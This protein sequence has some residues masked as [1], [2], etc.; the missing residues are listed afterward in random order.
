[1]V[2]EDSLLRALLV[3]SDPDKGD[4]AYLVS[5]L[6]PPWITITGDSVFCRPKPGDAGKASISV[7]VTDGEGLKDTLVKTITVLFTNHP[8]VLVSWTS[9]DSVRMNSPL[10]GSFQ[11]QD[12][13]K[14]DSV[15]LSWAAHPA[16]L[17]VQH[18][19]D[20]ASVRTFTLSGTPVSVN[21]GAN[22][23]SL[24]ISDKNGASFAVAKSVFVVK[25][26]MPPVAV[27]RKDQTLLR[28]GAIRYVVS[29]TDDDDTVFAFKTAVRSLDDSTFILS[30]NATG[31][32]ASTMD[33]YPLQ[34][35]RYEFSVAAFDHQGLS[36][37]VTPKDTFAVSGASRRTFNGDTNWQ[38]VSIPSRALP[39][40]QIA[41]SG[42]ALHWDESMAEVP[43]YGYYRRADELGQTAPG[44]SYWRKS[45]DTAFIS[46]TRGNLIDSAIH[47]RLSK[48]ACGWNQVASPYPYPV[49][50]TAT[51]GAWKWNPA[52]NDFDDANGTLSP[53]Q[54]YWVQTDSAATVPFD[55]APD[56]STAALSKRFAARFTAAGEWQVRVILTNSINTDA[57]NILGLSSSA[58]DGYNACDVA[59]PP[60]MNNYQRLYFYHPD[61][62]RSITEYARDIRRTLADPTIFQ[63]GISPASGARNSK[64]S[65]EGVETCKGVYL[66]LADATSI[67]AVAAGQ[68]YPVAASDKVLY[69]TLFVSP[70]RDFLKRYPRTFELASPYPNPVR[71][72]ANIKYTLPY[73]FGAAGQL[74]LDPYM[75]K[76]SLY[77]AR[78][79]VVRQLV[80]SQKSP[81]EYAARWDGKDNSGLYVA[82]GVY[83]LRLEAGLFSGAKRITVVR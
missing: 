76:L 24:T 17:S 65:F 27:I 48:D 1:M 56:F 39:I 29:A 63:M 51:S 49:K 82:S 35:G 26:N 59:E 53:W 6:I 42:Y 5:S 73:R 72:I 68:A 21:V 78:G 50:W 52:T 13:D 36:S 31:V 33:F 12:I 15:V 4:S 41:G 23:F 75:V 7:V 81:G 55:N 11:V 16:W 47:L 60:R 3:L 32:A 25:V 37:I 8:P 9:P 83:M 64:I 79:R 34:D 22:A 43:I 62:K 10:S 69:K 2:H 77:D 71:Q 30:R 18:V 58:Q 70:D 54:G 20:S 19:S 28:M 61:W 46:L 40:G 38:M 57:Q 44:L 74:F 80:Y 67:V 66:F 45:P 14:N